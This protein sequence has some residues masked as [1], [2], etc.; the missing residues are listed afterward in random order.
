MDEDEYCVEYPFDA[1]LFN[2]SPME[3]KMNK[4]EEALH[5]SIINVLEKKV[6]KLEWDLDK[7]KFTTVPRE[8]FEALLEYLRLDWQRV[9]AHVEF[10][11]KKEEEFTGKIETVKFYPGKTLTSE[12]ISFDYKEE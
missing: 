11:P 2:N 6:I 8:T 9:E 3:D 10:F 4:S 7:L 12:E 1:G 5:K